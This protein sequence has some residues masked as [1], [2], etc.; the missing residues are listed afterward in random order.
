MS[1]QEWVK[2]QIQKPKSFL[3]VCLEI[4]SPNSNTYNIQ[5]QNDHGPPITRVGRLTLSLKKTIDHF[6]AIVKRSSSPFFRQR[7][8]SPAKSSMI[9]TGAVEF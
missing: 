6:P 5:F 1:G 2:F 8:L 7:T 3:G 9:C 4:S